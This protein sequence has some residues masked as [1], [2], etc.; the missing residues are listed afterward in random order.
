MKKLAEYEDIG[1]T[2]EEIKSFL[3]DFGVTV[4]RKNIELIL[5]MVPLYLYDKRKYSILWKYYK[6]IS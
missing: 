2:P 6:G 3:T 4:V 5:H 1:L